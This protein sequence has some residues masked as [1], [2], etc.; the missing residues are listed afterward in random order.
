MH[1]EWPSLF[2][3]ATKQT[4]RSAHTATF[5]KSLICL[6]P[7]CS[8]SASQYLEDH[9]ILLSSGPSSQELPGYFVYIPQQE[10]PPET[11]HLQPPSSKQN[12]NKLVH[13]RS[14]FQPFKMSCETRGRTQCSSQ[15][16]L[17]QQ[18]RR[19]DITEPLE[20]CYH[21]QLLDKLQELNPTKYRTLKSKAQVSTIIQALWNLGF[22]PHNGFGGNAG[23]EQ[24]QQSPQQK[25][26]A[27]LQQQQH[28][29]H[30]QHNGSLKSQIRNIMRR[31]VPE[32]VQAIISTQTRPAQ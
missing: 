14:K 27:H 30:Q 12:A 9:K 20:N 23:D 29:Q 13:P 28:Q 11:S 6:L 2:S 18:A 32:C 24:Q 31:L 5:K 4:G 17:S 15:L 3:R 22:D 21:D 10:Q 19:V 1:K 8:L 25:P 26:Q 16:S 7:V